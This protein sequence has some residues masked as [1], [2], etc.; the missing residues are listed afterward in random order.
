MN[1]ILIG[2]S[3]GSALQ[4]VDAALVRVSGIGLDTSPHVEKTIRTPFPPTTDVPRN[5]AEATTH[6]IRTVA[7]QANVSPRDVFALGLLAPAHNETAIPWG[8]IADRV[9]EQT[10][11][12]VIHAFRARDIAAGGSGQPIAA[13][14][15]HLLFRDTCESRLLVHLGAVTSVLLLPAEGKISGALGFEAGP[16]NLL[17]DSLVKHGTRGRETIDFGGKKAVQGCCLDALLKHW[18]EHPYL[19]RRPPKAVHPEAF[20]KGFIAAA[21]EDARRLGAGLPDLLCTATHLVASSVADAVKRWLPPGTPRV[22]LSGGGVRNGFLLSL[23]TRQFEGQAVAK[24]DEVGVS[25]LGRVAAGAAVLATL[26]CDGV[27]GSLPLLTGAMGGRLL[28]QF[29]PGEA[30]NWSRVATWLADQASNT[31]RAAH[32]A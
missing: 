7:V 14:A 23:V 8:D 13:A 4:G 31:T 9:A 6:A 30:R 12:T 15:D 24:L 1:R 29:V 10:G 2:V 25:A 20:G 17:L 5:I 27:T 11:L 16:G 28:G 3:V 19:T 26:A 21:F 22:L 32:A 18:R